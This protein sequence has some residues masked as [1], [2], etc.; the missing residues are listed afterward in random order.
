LNGEAVGIVVERLIFA[1]SP[2][3]R[4]KMKKLNVKIMTKQLAKTLAKEV[5][6]RNKKVEG[7]I[8]VR[9]GQTKGEKNK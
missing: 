7:G 5:A 4:K 2:N 6:F 9:R 1:K 8:A 3:E